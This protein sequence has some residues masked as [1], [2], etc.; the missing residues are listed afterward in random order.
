MTFGRRLLAAAACVPL[1][2]A[3]G[4]CSEDEPDPQ[5][6]P[7]PSPTP[8]ETTTPEP[9]AWEVKSEDGAVAFAEHWVDVFTDAV[10]AGESDG[11][12]SLSGGE[13]ATCTAI[14]DRVDSIEADGGFYRSPGWRV[15]QA[16]PAQDMPANEA[17]ISMRVLQGK[18]V[19]RE[20]AA[21]TVVRNPSSRATYSARLAWADGGWRMVDLR[22]ET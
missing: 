7:S 8:T 3:L 9:E 22:V 10:N 19:F 1:L 17:L 15:L 12:R 16:V 18:E 11:L 4:A 21:S 5:F 14:A 20:S 2:A 6:A 13:C